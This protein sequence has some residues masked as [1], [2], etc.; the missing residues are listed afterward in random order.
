VRLLILRFLL[1]DCCFTGTKNELRSLTSTGLCAAALLALASC[2]DARAESDTGFANFAFASELG[3]GLYEV[4]GHTV[5]VYQLKPSHQLREAPQPGAPPGIKLIFPVTVG[6]FTTSSDVLQLELP[7]SV[8]ALSFEPGVQLDYWLHEDWHVYPYVK[9]GAT[10]SST[11]AVNALIYG[12]GVRSDFRFSI[13]NGAGLWTTELLR[14]GVHY[15]HSSTPITQ[16]DPGDPGASPTTSLPDDAFTRLR[17]GAELRHGV[18]GLLDDRRPE[19]GVYGIIDIYSDAP[20][21]PATGISSR[22]VQYEG[23]LM[24]GLN[25]MYQVWGFPVPRIGIGYREAGALSGWRIVL[26]EPF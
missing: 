8:G 1:L 16:S 23:G 12:I 6:F 5:Q 24:F 3:S 4:Q 11:T 17:N 2:P 18:G 14:A 15:T 9:A 25:P 13:F 19:I 7:T 26:G 22:T 21:G 20:S 10:F